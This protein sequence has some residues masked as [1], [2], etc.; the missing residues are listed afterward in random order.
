[1][2]DKVKSVLSGILDC[3]QSGNIAEPIAFAMFPKMDIPSA[4]WSL[5]NRT[6]MFMSGTADA[7][8]FRQWQ[9]VNRYVKKGSKAIYIMVP[10]IKKAEDKSGNDMQALKGFG[11][12][13]VF[14]VEDTD[15][16]PLDYQQI[17][18]PALPLIEKAEAWG[19]SVKAIPGNYSYY[20]YFSSSRKE[21]ALASNQEC[22]FFHELA[23]AAHE[24]ILGMLKPGQ[25]PLEEIVAELSALVLCKIVG[26]QQSTTQ[27]N[28]YRYI[29]QY[30]EKLKMSVHGACLKVL[31]ETEKVLT[32]ILMDE[33]E[34]NEQETRIAA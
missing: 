7:R 3:F 5:I 14:R 22:V 28:S 30:A 20:G 17:E 8:G 13:P 19:L 12:K 21:I 16:E 23:H 31:T 24:K 1:M 32:L 4:K 9:S 18:L 25:D 27:G 29:E 6:I 34:T 11:V 15:G 2:N 33:T 26:K 10:F